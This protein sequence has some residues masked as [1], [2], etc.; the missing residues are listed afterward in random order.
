MIRWSQ[1]YVVLEEKS[2]RQ[3]ERKKKKKGV[4]SWLDEDTEQNE[5]KCQRWDGKLMIVFWL[6]TIDEMKA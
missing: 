3:K 1:T 4:A 6:N 2:R 5:R